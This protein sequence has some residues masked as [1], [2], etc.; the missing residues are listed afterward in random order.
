MFLLSGKSRT[1]QYYI[2]VKAGSP[3]LVV[4]LA[5]VT[6]DVIREYTVHGP[7][8]NREEAEKALVTIAASI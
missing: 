5:K 7:Y 3:P 8:E 4:E 6:E 2:I 1:T